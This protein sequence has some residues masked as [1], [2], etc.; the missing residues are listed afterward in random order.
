[1]EREKFREEYIESVGSSDLGEKRREESI[2]SVRSDD[3]MRNEESYRL[4]H[5]DLLIKMRN[6]ECDI[7]IVGNELSNDHQS[8]EKKQ[9]AESRKFATE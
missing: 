5:L 9:K 8:T 1:M 4:N 7:H 6:E 2:S 3:Q